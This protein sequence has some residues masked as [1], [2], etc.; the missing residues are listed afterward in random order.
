MSFFIT[1]EGIEGCGKTTQI[2]LLAE[3]LR[4][5]G[6]E[7]LVTREP[8]G[9]PIAD[10]I[11]SI[12][13]HPDSRALVP[14]AEL[15]LYAAAR[16]QHVDEIIRPALARGALVLCD[17]FIDATVAYQGG[18]RSLDLSLIDSLNALATDSVVPDMTL[19]LDMPVEEGLK[20]ARQRNASTPE[21]DRFE[22]EAIDFHRR[23][24]SE[25]LQLA[26]QH[27]RFM[28]IDATGPVDVVAKRIGA[29]VE[30]VLRHKGSA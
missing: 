6:F 26:R 22:R 30:T 28:V 11:R 23:V 2:R 19:L 25:Y 9:C 16:A 4:Q 20:R 14:R 21:E 27:P 5:R 29:A 24:R 3:R 8:G 13:L 7:I 15:L 17:R 18:G 12:L 10:A 1:F